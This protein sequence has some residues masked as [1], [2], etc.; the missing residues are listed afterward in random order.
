MWVVEVEHISP[1]LQERCREQITLSEFNQLQQ[2]SSSIYAVGCGRELYFVLG[3]LPPTLL[4]SYS[5]LWMM[6]L[7]G[8]EYTRGDLRQLHK[9]FPAL[10]KMHGKHLVAECGTR[11]RVAARF[12]KFFGF[13]HTGS[14]AP[15]ELY[16][17]RS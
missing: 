3:V 7:P 2:R 4:S 16:E 13:E 12:L 8:V 14:A 10:I 5:Y 17:W 6:F 11:N 9:L 15:R 1:E